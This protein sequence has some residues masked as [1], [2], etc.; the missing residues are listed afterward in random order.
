MTYNVK[1][2]FDTADARIKPGMSVTAAI[3]TDVKQNV[4]TIANGAIKTRGNESYV[5]IPDLGETTTSSAQG[6]PLTKPPLEKTIEVGLN[7]GAS[8]EIMSG[9]NEGDTIIVRTITAASKTTSQTSAASLLTGGNRS[10]GGT[11]TRV[12]GR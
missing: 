2:G 1:V 7:N 8:T 5:Q 6:L 4:L 9:L 11:T 12:P 10:V 3:I